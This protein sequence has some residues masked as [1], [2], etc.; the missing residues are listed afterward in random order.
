MKIGR[1]AASLAAQ[2]GT[3]GST[4]IDDDVVF[5]GQSGSVGHV[6]IGK[7][8]IITAKSGVTHDLDPNA[9]VSG[10]PAFDLAEW[11][12]ASVLF[13][14][15]GRKTARARRPS[16]K[17]PGP[18]RPPRRSAARHA[19]TNAAPS[20]DITFP[21]WFEHSLC[22]RWPPPARSCSCCRWLAQCRPTRP[23]GLPSSTTR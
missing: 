1:R 16:P 23:C 6:R 10:F 15:S 12:K 7:G 2:V 21:Q 17:R 4:T 9:V 5:A 18:T 8:A 3:S 11:K 20:G 13:R 19:Q 14:L 22:A